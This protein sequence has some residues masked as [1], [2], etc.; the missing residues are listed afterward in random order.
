MGMF[1]DALGGGG[2]SVRA[3]LMR[4]IDPYAVKNPNAQSVGGS[5]MGGL[6]SLLVPPQEDLNRLNEIRSVQDAMMQNGEYSQA[7][8]YGA[9]D[10]AKIN[11]PNMLGAGII[12]GVGAKTANKSALTAAQKMRKDGMGRDDIWKDTG[13]FKDVDDQWKFEI[14]DSGSAVR[15]ETYPNYEDLTNIA[16][17]EHGRGASFDSLTGDQQANILSSQYLRYQADGFGLGDVMRHKGV[18]DA[19]P[20][21][22]DDIVF[23]LT[24]RGDLPRRGSYRKA[25]PESEEFVGSSPEIRT[26][27]KD[28]GDTRSTILHELQHDIQNGEGFAQGGSPGMFGQQKEAEL[29]R[30]ALSW[31][32]ELEQFP[33]GMDGIAKHN[34]LVQQYQ[35]MDAMDW[36]P[37][38]EARDLA[39]DIFNN[40]NEQLE[41]LVKLYRMDKRVSAQSPTEL[42][43]RLAGEA[44]A[45]NVQTRMDYTPEQRAATPPWKTL[46]VP[47]DELL[48]QM[49]RK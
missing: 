14:D 3:A 43:R 44:E 23:N 5:V 37:S 34:A 26:F 46:D 47:E 8:K 11:A 42:Y 24:Q 16:S 4:G 15:T 49:L 22:M 7:L 48:V 10:W 27:G 30:K 28:K 41:E 39:E 35:K 32:R 20:E 12:A 36:L 29:A 31:R 19:Y 25:V 38:R 17:Q 6:K 33:K 18:S 2:G 9:G 40:P 13:W 21:R 1:S 45:R